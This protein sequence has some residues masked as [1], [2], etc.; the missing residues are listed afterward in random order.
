MAGHTAALAV[1]PWCGRWPMLLAGLTPAETRDG[2]FLADANG[3]AL[4]I[5]STVDNRPLLAVSAGRPLT[6]AGE[7]SSGGLR[8]TCCWDDGRA[9]IL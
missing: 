2:W 5:S 7:W 8:P 3:I 1:D 4:P 6:V 9:V